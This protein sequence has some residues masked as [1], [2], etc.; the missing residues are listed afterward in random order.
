MPQLIDAASA[1]R[2]AALQGAPMNRWVALSADE[3]RIVADGDTFQEVADA[4]ERAGEPDPVI[5]R[6]P[7][8]WMLRVF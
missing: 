2:L 1:A 8:K 6:V 3:S 5:L 4:A 7:P